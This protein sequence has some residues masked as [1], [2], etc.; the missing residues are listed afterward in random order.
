MDEQ[1]IGAV[2]IIGRYL[3]L[4]FFYIIGIDPMCKHDIKAFASDIMLVSLCGC[5]CSGLVHTVI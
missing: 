5:E 2:D 3:C 4:F 1:Y